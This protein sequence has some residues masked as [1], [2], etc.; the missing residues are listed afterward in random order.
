MARPRAGSGA[1]PGPNTLRERRGCAGADRAA[2]G[3]SRHGRA[4]SWAGQGATAAPGGCHAEEGSGRLRRAGRGQDRGA[5]VTPGQRVGAGLPRPGGSTRGSRTGRAPWLGRAHR[6][7]LPRGRGRAGRAAPRAGATP[8]RHAEP[9]RGPRRTGAPGADGAG[10]RRGG[11]SAPNGHRGRGRREEEGGEGEEGEG[12][13]RVGARVAPGSA[14]PSGGRGGGGRR[15]ARGG[16]RDV[17]G[18]RGERER[19]AVWGGGADRWAPPGGGG[20]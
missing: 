17:C 16:E 2:P 12:T 4:A 19:E 9:G 11:R 15:A 6:G 20:A 3:P 10:L 14:V 13:H 5:M 18:G 7:E 1:A 8:D